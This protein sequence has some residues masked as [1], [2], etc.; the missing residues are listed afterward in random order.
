MINLQ[1]VYDYWSAQIIQGKFKD[2]CLKVNEYED[3]LYIYIKTSDDVFK[4]DRIGALESNGYF[5]GQNVVY[6]A[7]LQNEIVRNATEYD[8]DKDYSDIIDYDVLIE[9]MIGI[10]LG[11][12]YGEFLLSR[13]EFYN[14]LD[15]NRK[16]CDDFEYCKVIDE[17][18]EKMGIK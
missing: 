5:N 3:R 18:L 4:Y 2:I 7:L 17:E 16:D 15:I 12:K 11:D 9:F 8:W 13:E 10:M 14:L 6:G 1:R